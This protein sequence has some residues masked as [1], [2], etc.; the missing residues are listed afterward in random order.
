MQILKRLKKPDI[1]NY[2]KTIDP[3]EHMSKYTTN[4]K[5]NDL[6]QDKIKSM[7]LKMFGKI[8]IKVVLTYY[9]LLPTYSIDFFST[10]ENMLIK[11]HMDP[12]ESNNNVR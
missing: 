1:I 2:D 9:T 8:L 12:E 5:W 7:M 11:A 6:L 3:D 4:I 10:Y